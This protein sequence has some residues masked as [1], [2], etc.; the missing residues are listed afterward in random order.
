MSPFLKGFDSATVRLGTSS[1]P[2]TSWTRA[3]SPLD[4][5]AKTRLPDAKITSGLS[6]R[7][8][9]ITSPRT[10]CALRISPTIAYSG[11]DINRHVPSKAHDA[12]AKLYWRFALG[13]GRRSF[14]RLLAH[15]DS[16][17]FALDAKPLL[18]PA[19]QNARASEQRPDGVSRLR[20]LIQ[21]IVGPRLIYLERALALPGSILTNDLNEL[22]IA[23]AL[24]VGDENSIKRRI[25]PPD[26]AETNL[27]H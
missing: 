4:V 24:R 22:P 16:R 19:P 15:R 12:R 21:P 25:F 9:T 26:T 2:L 5:P 27:Y 10:P 17:D 8:S 13:A 23:W 6:V 20:T 7:G 3:A 1:C 14:V 11:S 18:M